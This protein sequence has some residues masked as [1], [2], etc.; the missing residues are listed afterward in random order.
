MEKFVLE[1]S[2]PV[3]LLTPFIHWVLRRQT[4]FYLRQNLLSPVPVSRVLWDYRHAWPCLVK[5]LASSGTKC[6]E[7]LV[8]NF[9]LIN[10]TCNIQE[11]GVVM[12]VFKP[13]T[14]KAEATHLLFWGQPGLHS[15]FLVS[16][17][18]IVSP[19]FK[20]SENGVKGGSVASQRG[21]PVV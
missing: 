14:Q 4:L 6:Q 20:Q 8:G 3:V 17:G 16:Q 12:H 13:M 11:L 15:E 18:Y 1:V 7:S 10:V 9:P 5:S 19:C 2:A 21:S